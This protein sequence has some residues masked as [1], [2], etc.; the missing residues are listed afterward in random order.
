MS[1][2][3]TVYYFFCGHDHTEIEKVAK[4][5]M[6]QTFIIPEQESPRSGGKLWLKDNEVSFFVVGESSFKFHLKKIT[7]KIIPVLVNPET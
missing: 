1:D 4:M 2:G 6:N 5:E 7:L 3:K